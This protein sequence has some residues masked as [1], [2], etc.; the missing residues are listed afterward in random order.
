MS[1][2]ELS[3]NEAI[4]QIESIMA[5]F[6]TGEMSVDMLATEVERATKL[7]KYC[8]ER[9]HKAEEDLKKVME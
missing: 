8:K 2:K 6:R 9:L 3:Y 4:A 7:I 1:T 5:K